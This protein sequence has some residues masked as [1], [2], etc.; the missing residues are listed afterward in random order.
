MTTEIV[1]Q[2]PAPETEPCLSSLFRQ[3]T[4]TYLLALA[5]SALICV[6]GYFSLRAINA[7]VGSAPKIITISARQGTLSQ[8]V[9]M[10]AEQ[11]QNSGNDLETARLR[12]ELGKARNLMLSSHS[13]LT[14]GN[15]GLGVP[16]D[17]SDDMRALYFAEPTNIDRK[18]RAFAGS[19]DRILD[20]AGGKQMVDRAISDL[21]ETATELLLS[22]DL[23]AKQYER[24][25]AR[26]LS[27]ATLARAAWA[28]AFLVMLLVQ[29]AFMF[30]PLARSM[31]R[32]TTD[33]LDAKAKI[34]H[35]SLHDM[36]TN[37]PNRRQCA[38]EL[39]KAIASARRNGRRVAI[40]HIDLDRFKAINDTFGH[41][42]GDAVLV[43]AARRFE[44]SIRRG[45]TIAR[46]GGD[47]FVIIAPIEAE[48]TEAA[49]IA[50]RILK[51]MSRPIQCGSNTVTTAASIG[52]SIFPDDET[53]SEQLLIN[54][55]IA[56]YRAK[57][58]GRSRVSFFSPDMRRDYEERELIEEDMR[59][60]IAAD[61]F[62]VY[63]QPQVRDDTKSV[64][65]M[66]ALVRWNHPEKGLVSA[67]H[68]MTVAKASGLII[69]IGKRVIDKALSVASAWN[70]AGFEYGVVSINVAAQQVR[71]ERFV[72]Y[73][74][75]RMERHRVDANNISVEVVEALL[76]DKRND[77]VGK[78]ID[79]LQDLGVTVELDDFGTGYAALNH[80]KR[81]K[82]N[83]LK[84][85]KTFVGAI[86][87]EAQNTNLIKTLVDVARNFEIDVLAEGV[88][89][90]A[91]RSFLNAL[92]CMQVQ[93]YQVARPMNSD[94]AGT[95]LS[96]QNGKSEP[97]DLRIIA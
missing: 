16:S 15:P 66:E 17:L 60:A 83:R 12:K 67:E 91:Q 96:K 53:D 8:R 24:E 34:E 29:G 44:R 23:A 31:A 51:K 82:I 56:L 43:A 65:G 88:E 54:A 75:E 14:R 20:E 72:D 11:L 93:G 36:L 95:W 57:D 59:R 64:V 35:A 48:P 21:R 85:D 47:E 27:E 13:A 97:G 76:T 26:T 78:M 18:V 30:R 61:E 28:G 1:A 81:Y 69:P 3:M 42:V 58:E 68:F 9:A 62:E 73:L 33:L 94:E 40:L 86:G 37:L 22:F 84:I 92:G 77:S 5:I 39:E 70:E 4:R 87:T 89:T 19:V 38:D 6:A 80:L 2:P 74:Q 50:N 10:L 7:G 79:R 63:F 90:E 55:D 71:D 25:T 49:R 45:D 32:R 52:I 46:L 41:A